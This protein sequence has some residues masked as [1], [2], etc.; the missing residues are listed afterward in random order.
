MIRRDIK[1]AGGKW[2]KEDEGW[3]IKTITLELKEFLKSKGDVY[4]E[5][6]EDKELPHMEKIDYQIARAEKKIEQW[7]NRKSTAIRKYDE[8]EQK[9][10]TLTNNGDLALLTEPIKVW[11]HSEGRHRRLWDRIERTREKRYGEGGYV[12]QENTAQYK[13]EYWQNELKRLQKKKSWEWKNAKERKL[14]EIERIREKINVWDYIDTHFGSWKIE[15]IN[16]KTVR[17][18][19]K[20]WNIDI[21]YIRNI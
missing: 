20:S 7:K 12:D 16:K 3:L 13:I 10:S 5:E 21:D 17:I 4:I 1:S 19:G 9:Y 6:I 8:E 11:H 15:K 2:S 18:E 14:A